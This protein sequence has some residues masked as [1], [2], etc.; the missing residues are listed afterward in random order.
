MAKKVKIGISKL[1]SFETETAKLL[2]F[3]TEMAKPLGTRKVMYEAL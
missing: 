2:S 3:E 1:L